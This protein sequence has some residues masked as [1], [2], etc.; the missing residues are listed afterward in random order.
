MLQADNNL[1]KAILEKR[2][3]HLANRQESTAV[4]T[5]TKNFTFFACNDIS[6][7][8][9]SSAI[10]EAVKVSKI[11]PIPASLGACIGFV[12]IRGE[13]I[14]VLDFKILAGLTISDRD[15]KSTLLLILKNKVALWVDVLQDSRAIE[16]DALNALKQDQESKILRGILNDETT[17]LNTKNLLELAKKGGQS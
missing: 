10:I 1:E 8:L 16:V 3:Q 14:S 12:S 2:A 6:F 11:S 4:Q 15:L 9:E 7:G 17:I 13:F 5:E